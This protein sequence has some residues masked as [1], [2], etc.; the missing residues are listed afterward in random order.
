MHVY[1][2]SSSVGTQI[3]ILVSDETESRQLEFSGN[4]SAL[5][6]FLQMISSNSSFEDTRTQRAWAQNLS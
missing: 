3:S 5:E 4:E 6:Q 1:I 2:Y